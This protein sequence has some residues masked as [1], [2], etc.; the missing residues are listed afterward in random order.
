M[1]HADRDFARDTDPRSMELFL[2]IQR[3]R[4]PSEKLQDVFDLS[5]GLLELAK[6]GVRL[7]YPAADDREVF[8]R[9]V[10]TRLPRDLMIKVY[11]WGP[12]AHG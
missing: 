4:Q 9:A 7:R 6:A 2:E 10:A 1:P 11:G 5:D 3:R 12:T 8:L